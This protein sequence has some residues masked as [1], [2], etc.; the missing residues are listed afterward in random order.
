MSIN[1]EWFKYLRENQCKNVD[2]AVS[3]PHT[4]CFFLRVNKKFLY[5]Q[6]EKQKKIWKMLETK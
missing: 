4:V 1:F 2:Y 5:L 6:D 3:M